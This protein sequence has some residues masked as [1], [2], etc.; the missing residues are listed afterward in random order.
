[1]HFTLEAGERSL[2]AIGTGYIASWLFDMVNG[3]IHPKRRDERLVI[4]HTEVDLDEGAIKRITSD[5]KHLSRSGP[6]S[7]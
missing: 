5:R 6:S 4:E 1:M 7:P 2:E 3:W